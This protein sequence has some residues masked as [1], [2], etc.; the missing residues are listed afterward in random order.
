MSNEREILDYSMYGNAVREL[1]QQIADDG[2]RPEMILAIAR[3]GLLVAGSLGYAMSVKNIYVMN[4]EYYTGVDERLRRPQPTGPARLPGL[5]PLRDRDPDAEVTRE[6]APAYLR[7]FRVS[8]RAFFC[9]GDAFFS[10]EL[11]AANVTVAVS[12]S[13]FT[14]ASETPGTERAASSTFATH[15]AHDM[16]ETR[17][18]ATD[19]L[20]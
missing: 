2:Y 9:A 7:A 10:S 11:R 17:S 20:D 4:C 19:A 1:A 8:A 14:A 13:R 6:D 3:G 16:P 5:A 18:V 12:A 15:D